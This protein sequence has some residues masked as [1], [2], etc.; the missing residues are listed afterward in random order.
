MF[1]RS[2]PK[3]IQGIIVK[4]K[5]HNLNLVFVFLMLFFNFFKFRCD[6]G[7][8]GVPSSKGGKCE[9]CSCGGGPCDRIT[10]QCLSCRG[11]TEG[12]LF[13]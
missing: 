11:N 13:I 3:V 1:A 6:Y 9:P 7:Y 12:N 5:L 2:V 8:F 4:C 10:G